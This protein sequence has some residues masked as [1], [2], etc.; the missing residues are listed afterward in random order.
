MQTNPD[1]SKELIR[2]GLTGGCCTGKSTVAEMFSRLGA[3]VVSA[4]HIV[5]RLLRE[6][7]EARSSVVSI[8][9]EE[10]LAT[11][12]S[13]DRNKLADVVFKDKQ[14]L[15][16][17]TRVLYPRVRLEIRR[18]FE[19]IENRKDRHVCVAEVPLLLEG[20]SRELYDEV[21]VVTASYPNQVARFF[22]RGGNSKQDL[23]RRIANQM[24]LAEK[25]KLADY[26][27]D[28]DG[29]FEQ[30]FEQVK[31]LYHTL[32]LRL[33]GRCCHSSMAATNGDAQGETNDRKIKPER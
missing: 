18:V 26:V 6:D 28:N 4:D 16:S 29:S 27:I 24:D 1:R 22:Q 19:Q 7:D 17:L 23:D 30:T 2:V 21:I 31:K 20:G 25:V 8:F 5:H 3:E 12:G 14:K 15:A 9:G 32:C 10:V 11:D 33:A 13:V